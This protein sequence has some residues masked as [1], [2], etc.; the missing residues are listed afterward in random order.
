VVYVIA[1]GCGYA[2]L[3]A[4]PTF[5]GAYL[6]CAC[7]GL[8]QGAP[9]ALALGYIVARSPDSHHAAHL[10]TMAQSVGY[11]IASAG[12]FLAG[13]L[14]GLSGGWTV[15]LIVLLVALVPMLLTGLVASQD[16]LVLAKQAV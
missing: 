6:W 7:L 14:H 13:W 4:A 3:I 9:L 5:G 8:G 10:S 11:L 16:R 2:G 1:G 15:P 12:P